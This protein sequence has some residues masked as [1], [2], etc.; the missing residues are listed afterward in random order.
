MPTFNRRQFL[1]AMGATAGSLFLPSIAR[2]QEGP[3]LRFLL[4]Y[5]SQG[6]VPSRWL[7]NPYGHDETVSWD[8]DWTAWSAADFS[9]SLRPL[10]PW[11]DQVTAIGGLGLVSA[12]A[13]GGAYRHERSQAHG[14][15]GANAAWINNFPYTGDMTIDQRI[16]DH[17]AR[18]DRYR[19]LEVSVS[20]GL[21]YDGYGS[22]IFRGANQ[23][24]PVIDD[25]RELFDRLFAYQVGGADPVLQRQGSV[26]DA[27][28]GR[29][30]TIGQRL[31]T[32]DRQKLQTHQDLIR[33]LEKML[34]G[35]STAECGSV[36]GRATEYGDYDMDFEAHLQL[37]AAAFSCDLT[38]VASMQMGQLFTNQL[39]LGAGDIHA[40]YA[41]DIYTSQSGE[42]AMALY[43]AYHAQQFARILEVLE[44]IPEGD[45]TLLDNTVVAWLPELADS[46]HGMDHY[47][48]VVAGG[49]NSRL[50]RGRYIQ[51]GRNT[52]LSGLQADGSAYMG[53][54]HQKML[55]GLC[56]AVGMDTQSLGVKSVTGSD[57][58]TIDCT[59]ALSEMLT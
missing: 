34:V 51:C 35:V 39:G 55:I 42:D 38:R 29:Y 23:P 20:N 54:P 11:A 49:K 9:D 7:C 22:A 59:G 14:L 41:H 30:A 32:A 26:L 17:L 24:L 27:V 40:D 45:G 15:T 8:E 52:P 57:G 46:W 3:P 48:T 2:A 43:M 56:Q 10:H 13:D 28:A 21:A 44:S 47:A 12:E 36:P 6:A 1:T 19:S 58:S 5:T 16:A 37:I 25:P 31:S 50:R 33:D 53:T 18:A 4:F